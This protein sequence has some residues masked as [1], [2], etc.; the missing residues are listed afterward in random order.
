MVHDES[1]DPVSLLYESKDLITLDEKNANVLD[2]YGVSSSAFKQFESSVIPTE[3][4]ARDRDTPD[5]WIKRNK[6]LI[7]LTG[8]HPFNCEAPLSQLIDSGFITPTDLHYVKTYA[9]I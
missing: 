2:Y 8:R 5:N 1:K 9:N 7:R 6:S 3:V 4:D